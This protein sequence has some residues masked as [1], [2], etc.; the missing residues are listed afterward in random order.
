MVSLSRSSARV[1]PS[2]RDPEAQPF[3]GTFPP[4]LY[5]LIGPPGVGKT[6]FCAQFLWGGLMAGWGALL[7]TTDQSPEDVLETAGDFGF[8]LRRFHAAD[9]LRIVDC[10][11]WRMGRLSVLRFVVPHPANLTDVSVA[12]KEASEGLGSLRFALDSLS[13]LALEAGHRSCVKF[14]QVISARIREAR[15]TG[16][17]T[18]ESG[19]HNDGLINVL[20]Y[21]L[22]GVLEMKLEERQ[23]GLTRFFRIHSMRR[24]RHSTRWVPFWIGDRGIRLEEP[25]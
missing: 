9:R 13:S 7:L 1:A 22:D 17:L 14:V 25:I 16:V 20:G 24:A 2:S 19:V 18:L 11:S 23:G 8:D 5:L 10:Y 4:G 12:I 15:G 21:T 6:T 3:M